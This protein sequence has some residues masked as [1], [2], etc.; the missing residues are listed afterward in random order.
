MNRWLPELTGLWTLAAMVAV[1]QLCQ[2]A[3]AANLPACHGVQVASDAHPHRHAEAASGHHP[4]HEPACQ[5]A[6][7]APPFKATALDLQAPLPPSPAPAPPQ[8]A[9]RSMAAS[10]V[11]VAPISHEVPSGTTTYLATRRLRI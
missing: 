1:L 7:L 2:Q 11:V 3:F 5:C 4:A 6:E 10:P 8:M 9:D